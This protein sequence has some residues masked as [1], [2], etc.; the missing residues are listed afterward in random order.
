MRAQD[1]TLLLVIVFEST[2]A[3]TQPIGPTSGVEHPAQVLV[4]LTL[5]GLVFG[6]LLVI[7]VGQHSIKSASTTPQ[8][9][10]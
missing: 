9:R 6:S 4:N 2:Y 5:A 1:H 3:F 7:L 8:V 10:S